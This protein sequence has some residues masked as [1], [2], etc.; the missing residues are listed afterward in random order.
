MSTW[1]LFSHHCCAFSP[2]IKTQLPSFSLLFL[3]LLE[4]TPA[5]GGSGHR[6]HDVTENTFAGLALATKGLY[7]PLPRLAGPHTVSVS[8]C[9]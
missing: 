5:R 2:E 3:L 1:F 6:S 7:V 4:A 9:L 8:V